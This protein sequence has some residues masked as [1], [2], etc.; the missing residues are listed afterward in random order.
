MV[1]RIDGYR[2]VAPIGVGSSATVYRAVQE[3][4]QYEVAIKVLAENL[5]LIPESRSRFLSEV[6]LMTRITCPAIAQVYEIGETDDGQ[7]FMIMELAD[8]GDLRQRLAELR[9]EGQTVGWVDLW[10]LGSHLYEGLK[11][12]HAEEIVHRDVSPGNILIQHREE[13]DAWQASTLLGPG[14]RLLLAD[15]GFAKELEWASGLTAGGGTKGFAAPEQMGEVSVVDHRAD[16]FSAT[17]VLDWSVYDSPFADDLEAFV[18]KGLAEDP[19]DRHQS[20]EEWF[21]DFQTAMEAASIRSQNTGWWLTVAAFGLT[22]VIAIITLWV[23]GYF[24]GLLTG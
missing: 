17:A 23:G 8:R 14:E 16:V 5:S 10:H 2:I 3:P 6:K 15:L 12:L 21:D 18:V 9:A 22:I 19:R 4:S 1:K 11:A 20:M 7:P 13:L 24:D